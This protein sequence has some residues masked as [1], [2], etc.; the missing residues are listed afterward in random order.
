MDL[1]DLKLIGRQIY[2]KV[3]VKAKQK[4]SKHRR[5]NI[6]IL[7]NAIFH[8]KEIIERK[9]MFGWNE[10]EWKNG[11]ERRTNCKQ[12]YNCHFLPLVHSSPLGDQP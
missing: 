8:I 4:G 1:H 6:R 3:W 5:L 7:I 9:Q 11:G 10:I 12:I 2:Q